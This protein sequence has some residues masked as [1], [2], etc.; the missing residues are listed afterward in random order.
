VFPF[1]DENPT[2]NRIIVTWLLIAANVLVFVLWQGAN[3]PQR[4][5]AATMS[6]EWAA[7]PCEVVT[8]DGLT[9]PE[10]DL[11]FT[12]QTDTACDLDPNGAEAFPDKPVRLALLFS[13]F[14]HAGWMHLGGNMLFLWIFG[15]NV[16]DHLG[17][18]I[19]LLFYLVGG[20]AASAAHI[21]L[22]PD[23]TIPV[24]GASGAVAAVMGAYAIWFPNAP[25]RTLIFII[26]KD[27]KAKWWL[28]FWFLSQF[29]IGADSGIAW[30]A[31]VGGFVF[32]AVIGLIVRMSRG[33]Q[34]TVFTEPYQPPPPVYEPAPYEPPP[35][36]DSTGGAGD[37][38]YAQP[39]RITRF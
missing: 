7:I 34:R 36:W 28:G 39:R 15:N 21:G 13:M 33:S 1:K 9:A 26:L 27:I 24:V 19:Y 35:P 18:V 22:Q 10:I 4:V 3:D 14:M 5:D 30:A 23:S 29:F 17:P 16:E 2:H 11:T 6:L 20:F 25:I 37:G 12:G 32:G 38:P 31:H 8:G